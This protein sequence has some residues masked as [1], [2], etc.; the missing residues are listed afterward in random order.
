MKNLSLTLLIGIFLFISC[1]NNEKDTS[2]AERKVGVLIVNHG[3]HSKLWRDMLVDVQEEVED[4]LLNLPNVTEVRTAFMEYNEP[5]IATQMR[6]FDDEEFD[7]VII[8]PLFLTVSSHYSHD[9]PVILGQQTDPKTVSELQ[10]EKIE[11]Y[12]PNAK[13]TIAPPMNYTTLLKKNIERRLVK[14]SPDL[15]NLGVLL[16]AYG[17]AQYNQQWEELVEE[18]G[19]YLQAKK[20]IESIAYAWC[21]H[22]VEYSTEPTKEGIARLFELEDRVAVIPVLVA[23][24]PYFQDEIIQ[25]AVNESVYPEMVHYVQDA[26]LPDPDLN[27][28]VIDITEQSL[29]LGD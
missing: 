27:R 26:I 25:T 3:S 28:W 16:V 7:E 13:L 12:K 10:K 8:V 6:H 17:D 19:Q 14:L 5:S 1:T 21:G 2:V 15:D 4:S 22:L 23:N 29:Q 18:I 11:V 9:I 24:D 20:G